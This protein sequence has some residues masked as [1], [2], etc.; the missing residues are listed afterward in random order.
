[1]SNPYEQFVVDK[2][3][4]VTGNP[5]DAF[6]N[7][8]TASE[9]EVDVIARVNNPNEETPVFFGLTEMPESFAKGL[10]AEFRTSFRRIVAGEAL[11]LSEYIPEKLAETPIP[12]EATETEK[13][14]SVAARDYLGSLA[15]VIKNASD[16]LYAKN[17]EDIKR[18]KLVPAEGF[19]S[20]GAF[21]V[22]GAFGSMLPT[23]AMTVIKRNPAY[24]GAYMFMQQDSATYK[25]LE[26]SGL[27]PEE[28]RMRSAV[29]ASGV[30]AVEWVGGR[31]WLNT[32]TES[33]VIKKITMRMFGQ[34][35]EEAAQTGVEEAAL[36][37]VR[38][39]PLPEVAMKMVHDFFVGMIASAPIAGTISVMEKT[40]KEAGLSEEEA[41][42]TAKHIVDNKDKLNEGALEILNKEISGLTNDTPAKEQTL[43]A[44]QE[45]EAEQQAVETAIAEG[46]TQDPAIA[47]KVL[48]QSPS[49]SEEAKAAIRALPK[50][51]TMEQLQNAVPKDD[52]A[53]AESLA[54]EQK[55][56]DKLQTM[57]ES[58]REKTA[59]LRQVTSLTKQ[60]VQETQDLLL[61]F[62]NRSELSLADKAKFLATIKNTQTAQQLV[63]NIDEIEGRINS[64]IEADKRRTVVSKIKRK[65]KQAKGSGV[66]AVDF[67]QQ[68]ES[69]VDEI[70]LSKRQPD[71]LKALQKTLDFMAKNPDADMPKS[72]RKKLEIL[73]KKPIEEVTTQ[74]L[75]SLSDEID[76]LIKQGKTKLKL[77]EAK[78][79]REKQKRIEELQKATIPLADTATKRAPIGERLT[80]MENIRNRYAEFKNRLKRIGVALNPMDVFFDMLD[81]GKSYKGANHRIFKQTMDAAFSRYQNLKEDATRAVKT[82]HDKL[83]LNEQNYEKIGAYAVLQQEG[84]KQKLLDSG[85]EEAELAITLTEPEMQMYKLM[86]KK[87]D[88]MLPAIQ[89][90]MRVVY[91]KEVEGVKDYFPFMTDHEAMQDFEIQD[92][93][94]DNVPSV[95]KKKNVERGF[96]EKR[97]GGKQNIRID[98]LGVFLKHVDNA[99]YLIEMGGD[100]K[101]LGDVAA[102]KEYGESA[103]RIGQEMVVEWIDLLA[104]KGNR[105]GRIHAL[106]AFRRNTGFAML[107]FKLST[108]MIQPTAL[109]D[110]AS[111]VGG[112]YVAQGVKDVATSRAWREFLWKNFPEVRERAGDDPAYLDMGGSGIIGNVR[113][114]GFWALKHVDA[115]TASSVAAGAYTKAVEA[116]GGE[117][118]FSNPDQ[119]AIAEAQLMMR[120]TQSSAF[121]KDAPA[122]ITQGKLTGNVS[123]DRLILQF[124]TFMLN[125]W[126]LIKHD[127]WQLGVKQG[128]TKQAFNIATW[129][130]L[131]NAAEIGVRRL[132]K[133]LISA[134]TDDDIDDWEETIEKEAVINALHNV[135]FVSQTVSA[136]EYGDVPVPAIG[137]VTQ[138]TKRLQWAAQSGD[139]ETKIKHLT[140]AIMISAG[141][142]AGI[143]GTMQAE[144]IF[145]KALKDE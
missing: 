68:I 115:L 112:G 88:E 89:E 33:P 110:G 62:V 109:A 28:R 105:P 60:Q 92:M 37:D 22:G 67:A 4:G 122:I 111:L 134:L 63:N 5:Y 34:G 100:I 23:I 27:T 44:V 16:R 13:A 118:D 9:E 81:G 136:F 2:Q 85:Y 82:L 104:R 87:L 18:L 36:S 40:G 21:D 125:R 97:V 24:A 48:L 75:E 57:L 30:S 90:V 56:S 3:P 137:A 114:A 121:A 93:L 65:A 143:P 99:A 6:L 25:E 46:S 102:S 139:D 53:L 72:V 106:D 69:L 119:D 127:M 74:E 77:L 101:A 15:G 10:E 132:T 140:S 133:E 47:A 64:L 126:S 26:K 58:F 49:T 20:E 17:E 39:T 129:L 120:R 128:N 131:A 54:L 8:P 94:G 70:D 83:D 108:I 91:N 141:A 55:Q 103:G 98:A 123:L 59:Q 35:A 51:F 52:I 80:A 84:G 31:F 66:I 95:G 142:F 50:D 116:K 79:E 135:P 96:T 145:R 86:R 12:E 43:K 32:L 29:T 73:N 42:K 41:K 19:L 113:Q 124:Q 45:I 78:K 138:I 117:V 14:R 7:S 130:I 11:K 107:G 76:E 144:Q 61:D 1:M 71:T 38:K